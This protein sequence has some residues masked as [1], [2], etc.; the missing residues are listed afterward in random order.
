MMLLLV[1]QLALPN[2]ELTPG[3][4]RGLTQATVCA[5]RWGLDHRHVTPAM[6]RAVAR[7]Y[8]VPLSSIKASGKGPCCELDH[9]IPRELAGA[10]AVDNLW[11]QKWADARKKDRLENWLHREVC[12]GRLSLEAAQLEIVEDW[13]A[14][15]ARI[16]K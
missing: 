14:A 10:D 8:G 6:R 2:L 5:T 9:L 15:F 12:A 3:L 1:L 16:G 7:R 13:P 11:L 4:A